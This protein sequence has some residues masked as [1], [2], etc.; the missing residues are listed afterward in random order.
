MLIQLATVQVSIRKC[1]MQLSFVSG[2]VNYYRSP[3]A[4]PPPFPALSLLASTIFVPVEEFLT[5]DPTPLLP[6][7]NCGTI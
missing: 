5:F 6:T 7:P 3:P 2:Y 4:L 1:G